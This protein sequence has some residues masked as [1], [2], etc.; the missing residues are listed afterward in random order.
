[1]SKFMAAFRLGTK[2]DKEKIKLDTK[3]HAM[4]K[5]IS[6]RARERLELEDKANHLESEVK[7][8]KNLA[9]E[10][11]TDIDKKESCLDHLRKKNDELSYSMSKAKDKAIKEVKAFNAYAKL[12]NETYTTGFEDFHL[13][14]C[15]AFPGVDFDSIKLPMGFGCRFHT[16]AILGLTF[17]GFWKLVV[18][19]LSWTS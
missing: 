17:K 15:E 2:L 13:D 19:P 14:A 12:L 11:R 5:E 18:Y 4:E 6:K 8:L 16:F 10:L 7:E 9:E 3:V 1:M